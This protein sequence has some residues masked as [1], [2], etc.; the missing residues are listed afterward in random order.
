MNKLSV[1]VWAVL[2]WMWIAASSAQSIDLTVTGADGASQRIDQEAWAKLPR[3]TV[4]AVD[5]DG[6]EGSYEGVAVR[7]VLSLVKA[8]VGKEMRG[9]NLTLY[10]VAQAADNYRAVYALAEFEPD[11]TDR[12]IVIADRRDGQPLG[13]K[14]GPLRIVIPGEK[15]QARWVRMLSGLAVRDAP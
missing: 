14:E 1:W 5:H 7:T 13:E 9:K 12:V 4:R 6:K 11:F 8:P 10:V 3:V 2:S 15:K